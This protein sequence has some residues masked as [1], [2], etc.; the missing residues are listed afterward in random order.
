MKKTLIIIALSLFPLS[1]SA[2]RLSLATDVLGYADLLTLNAEA[3]YSLAQ[4]WSVNAGFRYNPFS[5]K[6]GKDDHPVNHKQKAVSV[7]ARYWPWHVFS[8]WWFSG[9]AQYQEYNMGGLRRPKTREGDRI[10]VGFAAG[11]TY[12]LTRFLNLE[13]SLGAWGGMDT[14]SVYECPVCGVTMDSGKTFYVL[15]NDVMVALSFVF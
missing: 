15:P 12:M 10:G 14:Y 6:F 11:Y 8:G 3:S 13:F 5:Y 9:K 7:G 1:I 2:Q 4:H